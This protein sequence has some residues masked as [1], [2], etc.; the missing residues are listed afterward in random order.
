MPAMAGI[1][2]DA[3]DAEIKRPGEGTPA[4]GQRGGGMKDDW[5]N[6]RRAGS[7]EVA[8][9]DEWTRPDRGA[10]RDRI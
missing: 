5:P 10:R 9:G 7:D 8:N 1:N 2:D 4:I 6:G 3:A